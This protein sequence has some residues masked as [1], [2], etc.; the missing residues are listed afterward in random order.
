[1]LAQ[2]GP[3][4]TVLEAVATAVG[5]GLVLGSVALGAF[6]LVMGWSRRDIERRA[7]IDGY[8]GGAAGAFFAL[9]D[10]ALRYCGV[11]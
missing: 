7:L 10:L 2:I 8:A 11:K 6:G 3:F 4:T 1:M 5:A 9:F